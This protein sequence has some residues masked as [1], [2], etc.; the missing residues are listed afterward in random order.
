[1]DPYSIKKGDVLLCSTMEGFEGLVIN[2]ERGRILF[3]S[4]QPYQ[5]Y[6]GVHRPKGFSFVKRKNAGNWDLYYLK[7]KEYIVFLNKKIKEE[8]YNA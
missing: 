2:T 6:E 5:N 7:K 3:V 1:M 4:L 8:Y